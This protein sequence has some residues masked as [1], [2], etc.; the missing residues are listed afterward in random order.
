MTPDQQVDE[1]R[2]A[3]RAQFEALGFSLEHTG[4][5]CTAFIR[6]Y[7]DG[8]S[9]YATSEVQAPEAFAEVCDFGLYDAE[10]EPI[11]DQSHSTVEALLHDLRRHRDAQAS[12]DHMKACAAHTAIARAVEN[13]RGAMGLLKAIQGD[14]LHETGADS[15]S[16][17]ADVAGKALAVLFTWTANAEV[18]NLPD[19]PARFPDPLPDPDCPTDQ[20]RADDMASRVDRAHDLAC[21]AHPFGWDVVEGYTDPTDHPRPR[22]TE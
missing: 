22:G 18:S 16:Y 19:A 2:A 14:E 1:E 13:L 17:A 6:C 11:G 12:I 10:G 8:S 20:Q 7:A 4:G 9:H 5:N 15:V 21:E 3:V